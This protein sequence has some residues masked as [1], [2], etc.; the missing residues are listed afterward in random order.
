MGETMTLQEQ[1][2]KELMAAIKSKDESKKDAI[3]VVMGE[4]GRSEKKELPDDDVIK[5]IKKLIKSEKEVLEKSGETEASPF[6]VHI[7]KYLPQM[8]SDD[9]VLAWIKENVDFSQFKNKMQAM[10]MIMKHFGSSADGNR[11]K[12][13]LQEV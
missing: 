6:I 1:L 9:D 10:G 12:K 7:E 3:R 2:K 11:V 5:I 4:L 8:A 13:I